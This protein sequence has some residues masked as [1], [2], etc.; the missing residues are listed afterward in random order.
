MAGAQPIPAETRRMMALKS[1]LP[2]AIAATNGDAQAPRG[3]RCGAS[4]GTVTR[5]SPAY[6][7]RCG[8]NRRDDAPLGRSAT[9]A[10]NS[11]FGQSSVELAGAS[12][13]IHCDEPPMFIDA[14]CEAIAKVRSR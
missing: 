13:F 2:S 14:V 12:H 3:E 5:R 8:T 1:T 9:S 11:Q 4:I 7:S 6:R 10:S